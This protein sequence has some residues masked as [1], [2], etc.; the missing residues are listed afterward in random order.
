MLS[1]NEI[2]QQLCHLKHMMPGKNQNN[3][4]RKRKR[5]LGELIWTKKVFFLVRVLIKVEVKT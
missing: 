4:D 1:S 5:V 2:M 3:V